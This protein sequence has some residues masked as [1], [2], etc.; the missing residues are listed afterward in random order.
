MIHE[1]ECSTWYGHGS[2]VW[3]HDI[4]WYCRAPRAFNDEPDCGSCRWTSNKKLAMK[5]GED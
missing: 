2:A 4:V 1:W 5:Y 3:H